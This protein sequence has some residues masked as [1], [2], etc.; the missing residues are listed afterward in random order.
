[1]ADTVQITVCGLGGQGILLIGGLLGEAAVRDG[2]WAAGSSSYGAQARGSACRSELVISRE[3]ADFPHVLQADLLVAMAQG[4]YDQY[5]AGLGPQGLAIY[6]RPEVVPQSVD[7]RLHIAVPATATAVERFGSRQVAN[8]V[9]LGALVAL[10][11]V[12]SSEALAAVV[13]EG[14]DARFRD[15]NHQAL[16]AG[17]ALGETARTEGGERLETWC[18]RLGL[19][20]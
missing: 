11:P 12:V 13:A 20:S 17:L 4:A 9:M 16:A 3:P 14:L 19:S 7:P 2:L 10:S 5:L 1:M 15:A 6:D 8:I 18:A